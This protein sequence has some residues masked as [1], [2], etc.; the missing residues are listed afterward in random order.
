MMDA[1]AAIVM[2]KLGLTMTE[3][4]LASWRI[5]AGDEVRRGDVLFVVETEKVANEVV[6][7]ADGRIRALLVGEGETAPVG[8]AVAT[9]VAASPSPAAARDRGARIV[10]TPFARGQAKSHGLDLAAVAG[11]GPGGRIKG[12]D[13]AAAIA[14]AAPGAAGK[15]TLEVRGDVA[16][17]RG[18]SPR[19]AN[20]IERTIARRLTESKRTIPHFYVLAAADVGSL[21]EF[22]A[23][24]NRDQAV[25][26]LT[27]THFLVAA[28]AR[29]LADIPAANRVWRDEAIVALGAID[30]G[31]AVEAERGLAAPVLRDADRLGLAGIAAAV[32][33][34]ARRA[35]AGAL[36]ADD[37]EGGAVAIS[38][39]GMYGASHIVPII[40]P[41]QSA[42]LGVGAVRPTFRPDAAG[43]PKLCRELGLVLSCDHRVWDGAGAARFL[44]RV[45]RLLENPLLLLR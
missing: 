31:L 7:E 8:A 18:A 12:A 20:A 27:I 41:G 1:D 3:G 15:A 14:R 5:A 33:D 10:A 40:N 21:D 38:N 23:R 25:P 24:M 29:A 36:K 28:L 11:S 45:T 39:V 9:W 42:I 6:A 32:A 2:P 26:H 44:D 34:L 13:V 37:I 35:R 19:P 4:L 16:P 22:R 43:A 30:I 17:G